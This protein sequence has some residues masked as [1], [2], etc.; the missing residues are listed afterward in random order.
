MKKI[1]FATCN[2]APAHA[3]DDYVLSQYLQKK[4]FEV[5]YV[6]WNDS[7]VDWTVFDLVLIR[8]TWDYHQHIE[9][10]QNWLHTLEEKQVNVWNPVETIRWNMHKAYLNELQEKGVQIVPTVFIEQ[11]ST[12]NLK[13]I[14]ENQGWWKA[15]VKPAVSLNAFHTWQTDVATAS[16][17]QAAFEA[18]VVERDVM[19]QTFMPE[20]QTVGEWSLM[21]FG[22]EFSHAVLKNNPTGDFRI[23]ESYGGLSH[24]MD[25]PASFISQAA[26]ILQAVD[27]PHQYVRVDVLERDGKLYLMELELIEPSLFLELG[28]EEVIERFG[29]LV[30]RGLEGVDYKTHS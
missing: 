9:A 28:G 10:W 11:G 26:T 13:V 1:A 19:I 21:F 22:G 27:L 7:V 17:Q 23:Q 25:I 14:L 4:G 2:D 8:S 24:I 18:L 29:E 5:E 3:A 30:I 20:I 12:A 16:Q 6:V 15:V